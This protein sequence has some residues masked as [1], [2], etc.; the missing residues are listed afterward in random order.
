[1]PEILNSSYTWNGGATES[2]LELSARL[3]NTVL[4]RA[5]ARAH[6]QSHERSYAA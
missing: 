3:L 4:I 6:A 1:V 5:H 2:P